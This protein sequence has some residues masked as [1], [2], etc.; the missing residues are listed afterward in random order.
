M[1]ATSQKLSPNRDER[2]VPQVR[3]HP[4]LPSI[5]LASLAR[6]LLQEEYN[7]NIRSEHV[8][9]HA[10]LKSAKRSRIPL[11]LGIEKIQTVP[12]IK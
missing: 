11:Y 10:M 9:L 7:R 1:Y 4:R 5:G 3:W 8:D 12:L 6:Y 2:V